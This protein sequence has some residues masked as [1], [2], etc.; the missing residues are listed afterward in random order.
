[1]ELSPLPNKHIDTG[2]GL[3]RL[4][5][6][7][8]GVTSNYD[9]D[10]FTPYETDLFKDLI[11]ASERILGNKESPSHKVISDHIRS[12]SFLIAD[13]I[14]PENEGRGYVL[15][16]I[17]RRAVRYGFSFLNQKTP[18]IYKLVNVLSQKLGDNFSEL[19]SQKQLIKNVIKED[20]MN[21]I[22][23]VVPLFSPHLLIIKLIKLFLEKRLLNYM[24]L[25]V[26]LLI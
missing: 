5:M 22:L 26:S 18:F 14:S 23:L 8:Q 10:L 11:N 2:L 4:C 7:L 12:T 24:I 17:L 9:T 6:V 20:V 21:L 1:M 25:M 19:N 16:R 3:E 15:R 13:G